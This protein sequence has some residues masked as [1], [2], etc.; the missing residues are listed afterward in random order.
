MSIRIIKN[1]VISI[2]NVYNYFIGFMFYLSTVILHILCNIKTI[3][4]LWGY[5]VKFL[6]DFFGD[7]VPSNFGENDTSNPDGDG[8]SNPDE[9]DPSKPDGDDSSNS[10]GDAPK[11]VPEKLD[12]GK[13]KATELPPEELAWEKKLEED[14][15]KLEEEYLELE[16]EDILAKLKKEEEDSLDLAKRQI[17]YDEFLKQRGGQ[18]SQAPEGGYHR[19]NQE[20]AKEFEYYSKNEELAKENTE[21]SQEWEG[22]GYNSA[23][24]HEYVETEKIR[25]EYTREFNEILQKIEESGDS[26]SE[27]EKG[28]LLEQSMKIR[29]VVDS[30]TKHARELKEN[31]NIPSESEEFDSEENSD[32]E[33]S[34]DENN[35]SQEESRPTK[36]PRK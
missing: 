35:S 12:K 16:K 27:R 9:D 21:F 19:I 23:G 20:Q 33:Y 26:M 8:P 31:L 28:S 6:G 22:I 1:I 17:T 24:F 30:A 7:M 10:D 18:S 2:E 4:S 25:K 5:F 29:D 32:E 11:D 15:K 3:L 14:R 36:R 13:G 34:S